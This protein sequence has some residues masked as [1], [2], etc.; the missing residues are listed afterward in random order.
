MKMKKRVL[1]VEDDP[2]IRLG[3]E[4]ILKGES[5]EVF[6]CDRGDQALVHYERFKPHLILLD[7]MLP[8]M[9][10]YDICKAL[11]KKNV[12]TPIL[13]LTAKG[14]EIDKVVGLDLG[15]DDYVTKP[16]GVRELLA[17]IHALIRRSSTSIGPSGIKT[18][19]SFQIGESTI[20]PKTFQLTRK[21]TVHPL[22]PKELK[23]LQFFY[24]NR[25]TVL[26]RD[27]LLNEVWG[28]EYYGTTRTLDQAVVK[29]RKKLDTGKDDGVLESVHGV[30]Y[31]LNLKN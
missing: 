31:R 18:E 26:S 10:G 20:D 16:F 9:N 1:V 19:E 27:R 15:A 4:E 12:A 5:F 14:Q 22:T 2:S 25:G 17:R 13:M 23:L 6:S 3:L 28:Y 30:G 11:R 29:L 8:G 21:K 24:E 7:V